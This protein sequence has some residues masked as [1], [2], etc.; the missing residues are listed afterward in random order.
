VPC[1]RF[2]GALNQGRPARRPPDMTPVSLP[3]VRTAPAAQ[4]PGSTPRLPRDADF[5]L[6]RNYP[7]AEEIIAKPESYK[8]GKIVYQTTS[9]TLERADR[10]LKTAR[11]IMAEDWDWGFAVTYNAVLLFRA[12]GFIRRS[13]CG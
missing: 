10:D 5:A 4:Q 8:K 6:Y 7:D 13:R 9:S 12:A 2:G 3:L 11:K 1:Q